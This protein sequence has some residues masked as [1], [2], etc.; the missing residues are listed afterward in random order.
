MLERVDERRE[1]KLKDKAEVRPDTKD[2]YELGQYVAV[3]HVKGYPKYD[4]AAALITDYERLETGVGVYNIALLGKFSGMD[5]V[6]VPARSLKPCTE[7]KAWMKMYEEDP[8]LERDCVYIEFWADV[9]DLRHYK[10]C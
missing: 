1:E 6:G 8:A 3:L 7:L 10:K 4:G 5:F 2:L 9:H